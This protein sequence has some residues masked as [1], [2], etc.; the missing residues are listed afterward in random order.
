MQFGL[1]S[2]PVDDWFTSR[3]VSYY[4]LGFSHF[5]NHRFTQ[6][7]LARIAPTPKVYVVNVDLFFEDRLSPPATDVMTDREAPNRY[8]EKRRWQRVHDA[9]CGTADFLCG[10]EV[11]FYRAHATGAWARIGGDFDGLGRPVAYEDTVDEEMLAIYQRLGVALFESFDVA[12]QCIILTNTPQSGTTLGTA[13]ALAAPLDLPL[14]APTVDDL[15]TFDGSH[16]DRDSAARWSESFMEALAP[17]LRRCL[18]D[19]GS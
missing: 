6:P 18:E 14:V 9:L 1:S 7:L 8:R 17:H 16:L 5:E 19:A 13:R 12:D 11:A 3:S 4:L 10:N 2:A 15:H